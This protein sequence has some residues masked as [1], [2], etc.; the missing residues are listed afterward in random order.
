MKIC[1][2]ATTPF[3]NTFA[4]TSQGLCALYTA[5]FTKKQGA[6]DLCSIPKAGIG[7][8]LRERV[9][10]YRR[11]LGALNCEPTGWL[12]VCVRERADE[13]EMG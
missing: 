9:T 8:V 7:P 10:S 3:T 2:L 6:C 1:R 13:D 5:R 12:C 11:A 4:C